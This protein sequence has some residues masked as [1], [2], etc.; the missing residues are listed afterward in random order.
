MANKSSLSNESVVAETE[1]ITKEYIDKFTQALEAERKKLKDQ[2][3]QDSNQIITQAREEANEIIAQAKREA[4]EESEN[5]LAKLEEETEQILRDTHEKAFADA[6]RESTKII[7]KTKEKTLK[8]IREV[9]E[10]DVKQAETWFA[11]ASSK[12][13]SE[14]ES[15]KSKLLAITQN[16][17]NIIEPRETRSSLIHALRLLRRKKVVTRYP[18]KHGNIPL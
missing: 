11:Q 17:E 3:E 16:I 18:K 10:C 13:R 4:E 2:A 12:V 1:S 8:V 6:Q 5:L 15:E 7:S 9:I 14:L